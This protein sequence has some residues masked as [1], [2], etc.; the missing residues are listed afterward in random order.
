[1]KFLFLFTLHLASISVSLKVSKCGICTGDGERFTPP[2][3]WAGQKLNGSVK[4]LI[5]DR[6]DRKMFISVKL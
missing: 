2:K 1:M 5:L 6:W 3:T 4:G